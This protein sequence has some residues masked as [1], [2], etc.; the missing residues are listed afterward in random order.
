GVSSSAP[1][2]CAIP[3]R[4]STPPIQHPVIQHPANPATRRPHVAQEVEAENAGPI[5][6]KQAYASP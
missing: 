2:D 3:H 4:F 5:T 1:P 6:E